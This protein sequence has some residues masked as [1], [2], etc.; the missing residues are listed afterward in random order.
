M[1]RYIIYA[2]DTDNN[3][4]GIED[5]VGTIDELKPL[6]EAWD[7]LYEIAIAIDTKTGDVHW[8]DSDY[9]MWVHETKGCE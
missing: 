7:D 3:Y 4:H 2:M 8:Y 1:K 5:Y 6:D 9:E